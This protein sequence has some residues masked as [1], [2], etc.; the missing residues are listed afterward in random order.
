MIE[1]NSL[2][3]YKNALNKASFDLDAFELRI[4][5]AAIAQLPPNSPP[6][7]DKLLPVS[8]EDLT[9]IGVNPS[10]AYR[11]LKK[12]CKS[13]W[14]RYITLYYLDEDGDEV[15]HRVR[16]LQEV[17]HIDNKGRLMVK[18]T[19][20]VAEHLDRLAPEFTKFAYLELH[21]IDSAY[22]IRLYQILN[23][24]KSSQKYFV[25]VKELKKCLAIED[26]YPLY[27]HF[28]SRV[29]NLA[30]REINEAP[31]TAFTVLLNDT[32]RG[33]KDSRKVVNLHFYLYPKEKP[34]PPPPIDVEYSELDMDTVDALTGYALKDLFL[35]DAQRGKIANRLCLGGVLAETGMY[36][37]I[38][39]KFINYNKSV[40]IIPVD[41]AKDPKKLR[42]Y[43]FE[44]L[45]KPTFVNS[46]LFWIEK[47]D[48]HIPK[49]SR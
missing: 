3:V 7:I 18:F 43:V 21:S 12:A 6:P 35:N 13:L 11:E 8:A 9:A 14:D 24:Y 45:R 19:N 34:T 49:K 46:I 33:C 36:D 5:T 32:E 42:K 37:D 30:I 20:R 38:K 15:V 23:Q 1:R 17:A 4:I 39:Q 40:K 16:W 25:S 29:L 26:K 41:I 48:F 31:Y 47:I 44:E 27:A 2:V 10:N 22:G 28:K